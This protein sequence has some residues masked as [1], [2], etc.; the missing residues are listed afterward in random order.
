MMVIQAHVGENLLFDQMLME[1]QVPMGETD[2]LMKN[3]MNLCRYLSDPL[4]TVIQVHVV[5]ESI[6][7]PILIEI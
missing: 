5:E 2:Y 4:V 6:V 1:I 3:Y 7:D